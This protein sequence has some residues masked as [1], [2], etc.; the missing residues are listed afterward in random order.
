MHIN[1][2]ELK[3]AFLALKCFAENLYDCDIL[4]RIDNITA[5][6][7][8][9]RMGSVQLRHLNDIARDIWMWCERRKIWLFASYINTKENIDADFLSRKRFEDT[10]WELA[11]YA[12]NKIIDAFGL[13]E[14]DLF[15]SRCNSKCSIFVSWKNEPGAWAIDAFTISWSDLSFYAFPPFAIIL[16]SIHKIISD[17][18]EGIVVVPYWPTQPWYPIFKKLIISDTIFFEPDTYLLKSP[19]RNTHKLCR[20]L[21]LVAAKLSGKL[22]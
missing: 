12:Y 8:I 15:A 11:D 16:K 10:E 4:L 21:T 18:A 14:I 1:V 20:S 3:A 5:I 9:N 17:K 13:P 19:F 7:T 6:A 22:Y 2:L